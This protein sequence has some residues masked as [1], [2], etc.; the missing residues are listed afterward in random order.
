MT[1]DKKTEK[2]A[3]TKATEQKIKSIELTVE[4]NNIR[5]D[6][7]SIVN[8]YFLY[9][10]RIKKPITSWHSLGLPAHNWFFEN[11][12]KSSVDNAFYLK[13]KP[14]LYFDGVDMEKDVATISL[15][16]MPRNST[17]TCCSFADFL[18]NKNVVNKIGVSEIVKDQPRDNPVQYDFAWPDYCCP[19]TIEL[20]KDFAKMIQNNI[21]MG[22]AALTFCLKIREAGGNQGKLESLKKYC[23]S[24]NLRTAVRVTVNLMLRK[25][26]PGKKCECVYDVVYGGGRI[27]NTTMITL[28]YNINIPKNVIKP[29]SEDRVE[30]K[31]EIASSRYQ[32]SKRM[33]RIRGWKIRSSKPKA[34]LSPAQL[35][36]R[37]AVD[38]WESKWNKLDDDKK[39][40]VAEK[41]KVTMRSFASMVACRH[42]LHAKRSIMA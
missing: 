1:K 15:R 23:S 18:R 19:P 12:L 26:A 13:K 40:R 33:E 4:K 6:I 30:K 14:E 9:R 42:G 20:I 3:A 16:N 21:E 34:E 25:Y 32:A 36:I 35:R 17:I 8:Q 7:A 10:E 24:P 38:R 22:Q 2:T 41:Y 28:L 11:L 31:N 39:G 5:N 27:G 37:S 29:I